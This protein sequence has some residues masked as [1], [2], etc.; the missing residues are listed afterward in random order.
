M[1]AFLMLHG[2]FYIVLRMIHVHQKVSSC[3]VP[4]MI[5]LKHPQT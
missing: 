2:I 5:S 1:I 3:Y 4:H